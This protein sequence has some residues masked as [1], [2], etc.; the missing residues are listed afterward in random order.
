MSSG[1][2]SDSEEVTKQAFPTT[3]GGL[4]GLNRPVVNALSKLRWGYMRISYGR[5][6]GSGYNALTEIMYKHAQWGAKRPN[7]HKKHIYIPCL[8]C[9]CIA[10]VKHRVRIS[11]RKG[12][13]RLSCFTLTFRLIVLLCRAHW[14]WFGCTLCTRVTLGIVGHTILSGTSHYTLQKDP[15]S[16][17]D[18]CLFLLDILT[19]WSKY[20]NI[21]GSETDMYQCIC[22]NR[23][24]LWF[25]WENLDNFRPN[26]RA[27]QKE[28]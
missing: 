9:W 25:L 13:C 16:A 14:V 23:D 19:L 12:K 15:N 20:C 5:V 3:V 24:R 10:R 7:S 4:V 6:R 18:I 28:L 22:S 17:D 8:P 27:L 1:D 26:V 11:K 21:S 2:R